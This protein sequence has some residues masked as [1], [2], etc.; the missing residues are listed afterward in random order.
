M[1]SYRHTKLYQTHE[2]GSTSTAD[3][4]MWDNWNLS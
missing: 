4:G 2:P 3:I 1:N